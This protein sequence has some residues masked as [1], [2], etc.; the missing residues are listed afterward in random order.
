MVP[1]KDSAFVIWG[2]EVSRNFQ[3]IAYLREVGRD[4]VRGFPIMDAA[5]MSISDKDTI[6]IP[7]VPVSGFLR[8]SPYTP[9]IFYGVSSAHWGEWYIVWRMDFR[10]TTMT[11]V[12]TCTRGLF[13]VLPGAKGDSVVCDVTGGPVNLTLG[14]EASTDGDTLFF[15]DI[16]GGREFILPGILSH[17]EKI[18][19][20]SIR[21]V[22]DQDTLVIGSFTL[23]PGYNPIPVGRDLWWIPN[24]TE[25]MVELSPGGNP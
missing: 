21:W 13:W 15:T 10:D 12:D 8:P 1:L 24:V 17:N 16:R 14:F 22:H 2:V 7:R 20:G 11:P 9:D 23:E 18:D 25:H 6:V 19:F 3:Y 5:L 4:S